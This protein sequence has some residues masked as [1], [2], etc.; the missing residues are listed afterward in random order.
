MGDNQGQGQQIFMAP[1]QQQ[2]MRYY[3]PQMAS[4]SHSTIISG[5]KAPLIP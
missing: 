1:Q 5:W 3:D 2:Q 4:S